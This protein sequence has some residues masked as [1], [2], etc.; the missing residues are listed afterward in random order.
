MFTFQ[1]KLPGRFENTGK[2]YWKKQTKQVLGVLQ[3]SFSLSRNDTLLFEQ[4]SLAIRRK[5][6]ALCLFEILQYRL[7][8]CHQRPV[9]LQ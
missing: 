7:Q 3:E 8:Y 2:N 1:E 6:A 4:L 9:T 5:T